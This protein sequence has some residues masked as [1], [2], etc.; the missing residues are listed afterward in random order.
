MTTR[1]DARA[2]DIG[3]PPFVVAR[4]E[5]TVPLY[6][7]VVQP[8]AATISVALPHLGREGG[9]GTLPPSGSGGCKTALGGPLPDA[10]RAELATGRCDVAA[11]WTAH[12]AGVARRVH[13]VAKCADPVP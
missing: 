7:A 1:S 10:L 12:R 6:F 13:D 9:E 3:S 8:E 2:L 11:A 4:M 5:G